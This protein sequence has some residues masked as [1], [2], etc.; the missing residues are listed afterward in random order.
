LWGILSEPDKKFQKWDVDKFFLRGES[1]VAYL[2]HCAKTLG[3]PQNWDCALDF[4]CGV[5]RVT[6]P[7]SKHFKKC[8]GLDISEVMIAK[9]KTFA[10]NAD[11]S[12]IYLND[13]NLEQF[14]DQTFDLVY[15]VFVLQHIPQQT[16]I[17]RCINEFV[18]VLKQ[19]GLLVF[20]VPT[21]VSH[22]IKIKIGI[23]LYRI[24]AFAGIRREALY[25]NYGLLP[26]TMNYVEDKEVRLLLTSAAAKLLDVQVAKSNGVSSSTYYITK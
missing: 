3:Y 14:S 4:G 11:H 9:A 13:I 26:V 25:N 21:S 12:P 23:K 24:L 18:R 1:D 20:Q 2:M 19:N 6:I 5:G 22:I 8:Y 16:A 15:S 10:K 17:K 7:L